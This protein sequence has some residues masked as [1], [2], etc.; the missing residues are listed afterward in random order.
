MTVPSAA[1]TRWRGILSGL[2]A[3]YLE[4][5]LDE[6]VIDPELARQVPH[7]LATYYL[8][9]PVG[10][11]NGQV[12]VVLAHPE[13]ATALAVLGNLLQAEIVPVRGRAEEIRSTL[14][15]LHGLG[16]TPARHILSWSATPDRE[17]AVLQMAELFVAGQRAELAPLHA[18]PVD[19]ETALAL[20]QQSGIALT[21][22]SPADDQPLHD[23]V[24]QWLVIRHAL[25]RYT[26]PLLAYR[27]S[28]SSITV[29]A[30]I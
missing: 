30:G 7:G 18:G 9:L 3:N 8:A 13:N 24:S 14:Q 6:V 17:A 11:E 21:V 28:E 2:M 19:L 23:V 26:Q 15:R 25:A 10:R 20:A 1:A 4:L 29:T 12:S 5:S 27:K 16:G 22:F